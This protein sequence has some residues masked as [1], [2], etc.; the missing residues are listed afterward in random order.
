MDLDWPK[1]LLIVSCQVAFSQ[2]H[3]TIAYFFKANKEEISFQFA[4]VESSSLN[5]IITLIRTY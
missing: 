1:I 4:K 3:I 5:F 2:A